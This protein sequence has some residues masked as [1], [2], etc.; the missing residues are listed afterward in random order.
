M[1]R[2]LSQEKL[3]RRG[4]RAFKSSPGKN[5]GNVIER[6]FAIFVG[7]IQRR[8]GRRTCRWRAGSMSPRLSVKL[9]KTLYFA[10][11]SPL[12]KNA[13][14]V[15][16]LRFGHQPHLVFAVGAE[17]EFKV[18]RLKFKIKSRITLIL[19]YVLLLFVKRL[20]CC[21]LWIFSLFVFFHFPT[22]CKEL[23]SLL[24]VKNYFP[25]CCKE[26]YREAKSSHWAHT[27]SSLLRI[28]LGSILACSRSR[29][30]KKHQIRKRQAKIFFI[31][32][33]R[34]TTD[35]EIDSETWTKLGNNMAPLAL[36]AN[37]ATRWR[38]LTFSHL[39]TFS[40]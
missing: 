28:Q 19:N 7:T 34:G 23:F 12:F 24:V 31:N 3:V 17:I 5:A 2:K 37:L 26:L 20:P 1:P 10:S 8:F 16:Q 33:A 35:P 40:H 6:K 30:G 9:I 22:C 27:R 18:Q 11:S 25:T 36:I 29:S 14:C 4:G 32:I 38:H 21:Y 13:T 15:F 39:I